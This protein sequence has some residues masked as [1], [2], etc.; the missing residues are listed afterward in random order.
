MRISDALAMC[1]H[2]EYLWIL[3]AFAIWLVIQYLVAIVFTLLDNKNRDCFGFAVLY[4][5]ARFGITCLLAFLLCC[6]NPVRIL[7]R[8][9]S[10]LTSVTPIGFRILIFIAV[11]LPI[12]LSVVCVLFGRKI[13]NYLYHRKYYTGK[14]AYTVAE[15]D[16]K[17]PAEFRDEL[18]SRDLFFNEDTEGFVQKMGAGIPRFDTEYYPAA[19]IM[20]VTGAEFKDSSAKN[21][22]LSPNSGEKFPA[23]VYN[24]ILLLPEE[25]AALRYVPLARYEDYRY[26]TMSHIP[27]RDDYYI[28]CKI[29]FVD[30]NVYAIIGVDRSR[31]VRDAFNMFLQPYYMV[32]SEKKELTTYFEGQYYPDGAIYN[33]AGGFTMLPNT[34]EQSFGYPGKP[35]NYP[36]RV[37]ERV[38]LAAIN[39]VAAEL[40]EG[41]LRESVEVYSAKKSEEQRAG[42]NKPGEQ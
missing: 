22:I 41:I 28:E 16:C 29:L 19:T 17:S 20:P 35:V 24:A 40:Q 7:I 39:R 6:A 38:D 37:V 14:G 12:P 18:V 11:I 27:N 23:Y 5:Y 10:D 32:L 13:G 31:A 21:E 1:I 8:Y 33:D 3:I 15:A 2:K 30:G 26:G 4:A 42:E 25:G 9:W 34:R 36:V